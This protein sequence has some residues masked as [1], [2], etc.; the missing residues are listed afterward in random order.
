MRKA[1]PLGHPDF[2]KAFPCR[3]TLEEDEEARRQRLQRFSNLRH[4]LGVTFQQLEAQ[5]RGSAYARA[6]EEARS[7]AEGPEGFL[8]I[9]GPSGSGKTSLAAAVANLCIERGILALFIGVADLLD[10]LRAA[11]RPE[12]ETGYDQLLEQLR[13]VPLLVL[14]DLGGQQ[15]TPWAEE[16]LFQLIDHRYSARLATVVTLA[17]PLSRLDPRL[18]TRLES[19][20]RSRIVTLGDGLPEGLKQIDLLSAPLLRGLTFSRFDP[21]VV[22]RDGE[23]QRILKRTVGQAR[24]YARD[25]KG[26][27]VLVGRPGTGK[28]RLAAAIGHYWRQEGKAVLFLVVP[29][30]LDYLR[31]T[32]DPRHHW[33]YDDTFEAVRAIPYLI[34]DDLGQHSSTPWAQE[35]LFQLINYRYNYLLPTVFTTNLVA[36][37]LD[38]KVRVRLADPQVSTVLPMGYFDFWERGYQAKG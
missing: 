20:Y 33:P 2:G 27:L 31:S 4:Y 17:V 30:L 35:K 21:S 36:A 11:Y 22:T 26:F 1:V 10:H 28:T 24:A 15:S 29:D 14:D 13:S 9:T 19:P 25:P 34:L 23:E 18:R 8:V 7:F 5:E 38:P 3:C 6:L 37:A 32:F 12:A 16:K